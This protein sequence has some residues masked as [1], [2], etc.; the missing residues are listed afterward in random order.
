M[1]V[2]GT[3]WVLITL[4]VALAINILYNTFFWKGEK[5][6]HG[7]DK[8][9]DSQENLTVSNENLDSFKDLYKDNGTASAFEK[10]TVCIDAGHGGDD[11]GAERENGVYEKQDNLKLAKLVK[12][13][14]EA[15]D[16]QVVMTRE[17]DISVSLEE[18]RNIAEKCHAD[19]FL[20]LHR[21]VYEGYGEVNGIEAWIHN[22]REPHSTEAAESIINGILENVPSINN[23]GVK[24]G[25]MD[26][27]DENYAVNKVSMPSLI[28]EVG[29]VT[30]DTDN[31]YFD[32]YLEE[33]AKGIAEGILDNMGSYQ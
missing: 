25:T 26:N 31:Q 18:R 30:S 5:S 20:S 29:F 10:Y 2:L 8:S 9:S 32:N 23:R 28:L 27:A 21:N 4:C 6:A 22:S 19:L 12:Q 1:I 17:K 7:K 13:Y 33:I 16:I 11:V 3:V 15:L 14:L 24:W